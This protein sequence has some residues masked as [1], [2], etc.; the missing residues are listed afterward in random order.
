MPG[1]WVAMP[2]ICSSRRTVAYR[3]CN[4]WADEGSYQ[5]SQ[6]ADQGSYQCSQWADQGSYQCSQWADEGSN[7][8]CDWWPC[9]WFCDAFYWVAK[10]VCIAFYWVAN[11][12]CQAWYWV[13]NWVCQAWFWV[14]RW[15]CLFFVWLFYV[16][17]ID[18]NGGPAFLLTDGSI[19]LNECA[20]GYGTRRWW[21]LAPDSAGNYTGGLWVR[22]ADSLNA[23]KYFASAVLADGRFVVAGGEYSDTSGS[24]QQDESPKCEIYDPVANTWTQIATP[25][26]LAQIGDAACCMLADGRLLIA[27][28]N[29]TNTYTLNPSNLQWSLAAL[30][31]AKTMNPQEES[32]VLMADGTVVTPECANPPNAEKYDPASDKWVSASALVANIV[33]N[34]SSEI[35]PGVLLPDGR[36]FFVGSSGGNTALYTSGATATATGSWA[37]GPAIPPPPKSRQQLGAKDGPGALEPGGK[38]LFPAAPV[39]GQRNNYNSPC[40]FLNAME[41]ILR[42][43]AI[44]LIRIVLRM[45]AGCWYCPPARFSG[46]G[47][48]IRTCTCS[49]ART[50]PRI[51]GVQ[52]SIEHQL[53]LSPARQYIFRE[54]NLTA[55]PR[56]LLMETITR[57][58]PT[59]PSFAFE[60]IKAAWFDTAERLTTRSQPRTALGLAWGSRLGTLL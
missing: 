59:I 45:L 14:A 53:Q 29:S 39:D 1:S 35:G 44:L 55:S 57:R 2:T 17:C 18:G 12:V 15:V 5:C 43:S 40:S 11:W 3:V 7:Q 54:H 49:R 10:W 47:K 38:V 58:P 19:L 50:H 32:W 30:N 27:D 33:E 16:F 26:N 8:C 28:I 20:S 6:W 34:A 48:M 52:S 24:N 23:R 4:S 21:K 42:E 60:I 36:A 13:A 46:P 51:G 37:A 56:H 41:R 22:V 9:S 31:G 25:G